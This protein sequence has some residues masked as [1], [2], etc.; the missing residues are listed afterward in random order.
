M[1]AVLKSSG[2]IQPPIL[3]RSPAEDAA[4]LTEFISCCEEALKEEA[5]NSQHTENAALYAGSLLEACRLARAQFMQR[6]REWLYSVL[7]DGYRL[8][9]RPEKL[10][11]E[12]AK[13]VPGLVPTAAR[14]EFERTLPEIQRGGGEID[15]GIFFHYLFDCPQIGTHIFHSALAPTRESLTFL[16][17]FAR[18]GSLE[19]QSISI[20]RIRGIAYVTMKNGMTLN[21]EDEVMVSDLETAVDLVALDADSLVGVLRGG[22]M[23]HPKYKGRR[24]FCSGINLKSLASGKISFVGFMLRRELSLLNKISRGIRYSDNPAAQWA[25]KPWIGVVDSFAIGGGLQLLLVMDYVIATKGT[26]FSLPAAREGIIPGFANLRLQHVFDNNTARE[27][28]FFDRKIW[29]HDLEAR[30][31]ANAIVDA[32]EVDELVRGIAEQLSSPAVAANRR[33]LNLSRE[34][35]DHFLRYASEFSITQAHRMHSDDVRLKL[36]QKS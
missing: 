26:Y 33:L 20:Q 7:T 27:L 13:C 11:Y 29:S 25:V 12:A 31:L 1:I 2:N 3:D 22:V 18:T 8:S 32:D 19:L 5:R 35:V 17:L 21:A 24:V 30:R 34:P 16:P 10:V 23:S 36:A 28:L 4:C 15:Q 14:V 6:H 9:L